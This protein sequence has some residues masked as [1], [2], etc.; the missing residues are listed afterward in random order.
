[1]R[2]SVGVLRSY[3]FSGHDRDTWDARP[4]NIKPRILPATAASALEY[5]T[6]EL[7]QSFTSWLRHRYQQATE[8]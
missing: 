5:A 7:S 6:A 2:G 8:Q 3:G 4:G 1:M